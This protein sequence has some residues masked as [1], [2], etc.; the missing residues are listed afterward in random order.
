[1]TKSLSDRTKDVTGE[2]DRMEKA[3]E[4]MPDAAIKFKQGNRA[5]KRAI[6]KRVTKRK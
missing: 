4:K 5:Q 1:M 2:V 6:A 3:G